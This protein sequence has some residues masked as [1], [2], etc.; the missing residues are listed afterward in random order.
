MTE[1]FVD[2]EDMEAILDDALDELDDS[3]SDED[4]EI[5]NVASEESQQTDLGSANLDLGSPL[6]VPTESKDRRTIPFGPPRPPPATP[7]TAANSESANVPNNLPDEADLQK[8]EASLQQMFQGLTTESNQQTPE[9]ANNAKTTNAKSTTPNTNQSTIPGDDKMLQDLF[10]GLMSAGGDDSSAD[11]MPSM[12]EIPDLDNLF[13]GLGS[14]EA[15]GGSGEAFNTEDFMEGMM[16]QLLSKELMYEPM[17]QVTEKFPAWLSSK[18]DELAPE[19]WEKRK[20]QYD[21]FRRL[22]QAYEDEEE[23][24]QTPKLLEI[25]QEV[26]EYGQPPPEII[27]E[28]APGLDLDE[29]GL[30]KMNGGVMPPFLGGNAGGEDCRI[31]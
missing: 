23:A 27:N 22:V 1:P 31:M 8:M 11:G 28:I 24:K 14:G 12:D 18:K 15:S 5:K 29:E 10:Q 19:E 30:P 3:D 17:K 4:G 6:K 20:K 2:A 25:M 26:Q 16:E 7:E 9:K 13:A 21:C